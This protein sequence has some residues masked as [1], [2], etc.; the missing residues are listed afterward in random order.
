MAIPCPK[1]TRPN[2]N[3]APRCIYCGSVF[4]EYGAAP[5]KPEPRDGGEGRANGQPDAGAA[6][7]EPK[8]PA[9]SPAPPLEFFLVVIS[10]RQEISPPALAGF[11]AEFSLDE[12]T[13]RQ[14]LKQPA[15]W[16]ARQYQDQESAQ[17]LLRKLL[18]LGL[19]AYLVKHSGIERLANRIQV[20]GLSSAGDEMAVFQDQDGAAVPLRYDDIFLIVRGRIREQPERD[21]SIAEGTKPV[22]LGEMMVGEKKGDGEK[23]VIRK[24]IEA[25]EIRPRPGLLRWTLKGH[26]IEV[27]DLYRKSS[28]R[29]LRM[30]ESEF[31]YRGL[32]DAMSPSGLLNYT[33]IL[34][35]IIE[36]AGDVPV[37]KTFY[38]VGYA[39]RELPRE[40]K[41]RSEL[42]T[43]M[44]TSNSIKK[45][46]DN[47]A[48]FDDFSAMIYLHHLRKS[49]TAEKAKAKPEEK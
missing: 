34:N 48:V 21:E 23:G 24:T 40:N 27:V 25:I 41:I 10:P 26:S 35:N 36:R 44:G 6:D 46:Y 43:A 5:T 13:A 33:A 3:H 19:D 20:M 2:N 4:P 31:D 22:R 49:K 45:F 8:K 32:G 12:Y 38:S 42:E 9:K 30:V 47:R 11:M 1:C 14:K 15:P 28:P 39:V 17:A 7:A 29:A 16:Q 37:D 18:T